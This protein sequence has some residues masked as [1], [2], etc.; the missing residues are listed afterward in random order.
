MAT[1]VG[2]QLAGMMSSM[3]VEVHGEAGGFVIALW[4]DR[5]DLIPGRLVDGA[6]RIDSTRGGRLRSARVNLVGREVYRYDHVTMDAK[7]QMRT[8]T[9]TASKDLP[10]VPIAVLG[11]M[12]LAPGGSREARFQIPV[13]SLGP[14]TFESGE[15]AI[16]WTVEV[17]LDVPGFDPHLEVP[18][19]VLQPTALLRAGVIRVAEYALY[20]EAGADA[21]GIRGSIWL[22][23]VPLVVGSPFRGRLTLGSSSPRSVQEVRL[24][25]R[26]VARSTVSGGRSETITLWGGQLFGPGSFGGEARTAAFESTLPDVALP[27]V[28]TEHGRSDAAF[29]V[30][31]ALPRARD[32][33]LVRDVAICSTREV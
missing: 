18:V 14:A 28:E 4:L 9:K 32:P 2:E 22:D 21:G 33:H 25:L 17:S 24:E 26:V 5:R 1:M 16:R 31:V 15:Y 7:G 11:A 29:H 20:P 27:T 13:P 23:P 19:I 10:A 12:D 3:S 6:L 30:I 8:Q